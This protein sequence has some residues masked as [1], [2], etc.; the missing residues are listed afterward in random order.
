MLTTALASA[1]IALAQPVGYSGD[2]NTIFAGT[3]LI[4]S[5]RTAP[6]PGG[7][8]LNPVPNIWFNLDSDNLV[9]PAEWTFDTPAGQTRMTASAAAR[10]S[11]FGGPPIGTPLRKRDAAYWEVEL[12]LTTD[13]QLSKYDVLALGLVGNLVLNPRERERLRRYVDKGGILWMD[14]VDSTAAVDPVHPAP[15]PFA[16]QADGGQ[17]S[18]S[19]FHPALR[20]PNAVSVNDFNT[21]SWPIGLS[22]RNPN[23]GDLFGMNVTQ[24]AAF[25]EVLGTDTVAG[26]PSG[27]TLT[28]TRI[29]DGFVVVSTRGLLR[30]LN[31]TFSGSGAI[32]DA[33]PAGSFG[34]SSNGPVRDRAHVSVTKL[35]VNLISLPN[36]HSSVGAGSRRSNS[37]ATRVGAPALRRFI[38]EGAGAVTTPALFNGRTVVTS[39]NR[40]M[41][42]DSV[43]GRDLDGDIDGNPDDGVPDPVG[44]PVDLIWQSQPLGGQLSSPTIV[45]S[46]GSAVVEQVWVLDENSNLY[47]FNLTSNGMAVGPAQTVNPPANT[48]NAG[49][50]PGAPTFHDGILYVSD[51]RTDGLGRLWAVNPRTG[52][53]SVDGT[54]GPD[55]ALFGTG[56]LRSSRYGP[57]V[58]YIP[59]DDGSG[60][61]D[62][63]AYLASNRVTSPVGIPAALTSVW[64]GAKGEVPLTVNRVG[65]TVNLATRA[66]QTR[67]PIVTAAAAGSPVGI[68]ITAID[69]AGNPIDG[70]TFATYV[71]NVVTQAPGQ[72]GVLQITLTGAGIAS[73]LDWDRQATPGNPND[74]VTFRIDYWLD[75]AGPSVPAPATTSSNSYIRGS[76]QIMDSGPTPSLDVVSSPCL[77]PN[78]TVGLAAA[79]VDPVATPNYG[80]SFYILEESGRGS[81]LVRTRFEFHDAIS[82]LNVLGIPPI[83]TTV[84]QPPAITD[85]DG[86]LVAIPFLNQ[87]ISSLRP[88]GVAAKGDAF[89]VLANGRKSVFGFPSPTSALLAFKSDPG[90]IEFEINSGRQTDTAITLKQGDIARS[91][92]KTAPTVFSVLASNSFTLEPLPNTRRSRVTLRSLA[93]STEG[94]MNSC[95]A[96]NLPV[97]LSRPGQTETLVEPEAFS[98]VN[99]RAPGHSG[100]RYSNLLWYSV[101]NGYGAVGPPVVT[102]DTVYVG[103]SSV[104]PSLTITGFN[105]PIAFNGLLFAMDTQIN[106][107]DPFLKSTAQRPWVNQLNF[108]DGASGPF[109][110]ATARVSTS[111][112]WPQ[113]KGITEFDDFRIRILQATLADPTVNALAVGDGA[114]AA[115]SANAT[116][117]FSRSEFVVVDSGRISRIDPSGNPLWVSDMTTYSGTEQSSTN[118]ENVRKLSAPN[119][120]YPIGDNGYVVVDA[121]ND[122][123]L[124]VDAAG[125]E[126]RTIKRLKVHPGFA[127]NGTSPNEPTGLRRPQDVVFFSTFRSAGQVQATF[128]GEPSYSDERWDHWLIADAGNHRIVELVDRYQLD[129]NGRVTGVTRYPDPN[130]GEGDGFTSAYGV[131][132]WHTPDELSGKNYAYNSIARTRVAAGGGRTAVAF[133]FNNVEPSLKTFGLDSNPLS[134]AGDN[135]MGYG[136]VVIFD[137][138]QTEVITQFDIPSIPANSF[139]GQIGPNSFAFSLPVANE[140]ARVHKISGIRS[141]T[142]RYIQE[143]TA[144][145]LEL[146]VMVS[147]D[148]GVYELVKR[149]SLVN[150][151]NTAWVVRWMLPREA[152]AG[153]RR[154]RTSVPSVRFN[155]TGFL[156]N[157]NGFKPMHARRLDSGDV[158]IV[159]GHTGTKNIPSGGARFAVEEF[160]GEIFIADGTFSSSP[161]PNVPGYGVG[162]ANLGFCSLSVLFELPPV[163]G[164]RGIINPV[165][166]ERQ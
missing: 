17:Q 87:P 42:F 101:F 47:M 111:V 128:P 129:A 125:R 58:G 99:G 105:P 134:S 131:L 37:L 66:S 68:R 86:L 143:T 9:K 56:R 83:S 95:L 147:L 48:D 118:A 92:I 73:G 108:L 149:T 96:N 98:L 165:F 124:R 31:R 119:R 62:R 106:P 43:P 70:A 46:P 10:W 34:F 77:S 127:P 23:A 94:S 2:T 162:R 5:Q 74:D 20:F 72:N 45:E 79:V 123:V 21:M 91:A 154:A 13:D 6:W 22:A 150:P 152:Y 40:V 85:E 104:L 7:V 135:P 130:N 28:V 142:M 11:G 151:A 114:I 76:I 121:G 136:G 133:A 140:P 89:Y 153:M 18:I 113:F 52:S 44:S 161:N 1:T 29:G 164:T 25:A 138:A 93:S 36:N 117:V 103:G 88:T 100:G 141:V 35:A 158:L 75:L 67:A 38:A 41:V 144:A 8:L 3:L 65:A 112:K 120:M 24:S 71:T 60:G 166:A 14:M 148:S 64:L 53:K 27:R 109:G 116:S 59:I 145:P 137:G 122:A 132:L 90:P 39:G 107:N 102:G 63:V 84:Q 51:R 19:A 160:Y 156:G 32:I 57:T 115:T 78:G 69:G 80:G 126:V 26:T 16:L 50:A 61:I 81:F 163:Q 110:F 33:S 139:I 157:P 15:V 4:E 54:G 55:W 30:T 49:I 159:N 155:Q 82:N 97:I 146:A 12:A